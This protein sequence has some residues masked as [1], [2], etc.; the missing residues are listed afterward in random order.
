MFL[1]VLI[2]SQPASSR[3]QTTHNY[4]V[5]PQRN[6]LQVDDPKGLVS[7]ATLLPGDSLGDV[8]ELTE[9]GRGNRGAALLKAR[10]L[11]AQE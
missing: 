10:G 9:T 7:V 5:Q 3:K 4:P 8:S 11:A 2:S 1:A 6:F